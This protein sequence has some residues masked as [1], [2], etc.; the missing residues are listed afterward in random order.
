MNKKLIFIC[1][2]NGVGKSSTC[3]ELVNCIE[4]SAYVDSDLCALRNPFLHTEGI[5]LGSQ[6]MS[7]MLTK[8]LECST[9]KNIIWSYGFHGH[10]KKV[11]DN[12]MIELR[13]LNVDFDFVPIIL[14]CDLDENIKRMNSDNRDD[15]RIER[16][17]RNTREIYDINPFPTINTTKMT[18]NEAASEIKKMIDNAKII[19]D[20]KILL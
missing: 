18:I 2:P 20:E 12:I 17:I 6:F 16:A 3:R 11:F 13:N 7:F 15:A 5:D 9:Y 8:Y 4:E 14:T 19:L 10:R 1:G